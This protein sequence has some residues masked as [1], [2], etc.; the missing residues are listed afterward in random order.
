MNKKERLVAAIEHGTVIDHIPANKTYQVASLLGLFDLKSPVTIGFNYPS[1]KVGSK[2][3]IKVSDK[4]FTDAEISRLSV[5]APNVILSVIRDYEVVEKRSV[6]TPDEIKG[7]VKCNNPKCITN[8]EPMA[9]HF[10][11][12]NGI[13]TCHYCEKEQDINKVELV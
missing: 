7:I 6:V 9:T 11:V 3:I 1:Q 10:H 12:T 8:N 13:L 5:V 2:G 4:F